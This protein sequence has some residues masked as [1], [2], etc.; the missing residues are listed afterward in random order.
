M[1]IRGGWEEMDTSV[2]GVD[3]GRK[4]LF[5][6]C[7]RVC[8]NITVQIPCLQSCVLVLPAGW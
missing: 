5:G 1:G 3:L 2:R 8:K 7:D 4:K 6:M